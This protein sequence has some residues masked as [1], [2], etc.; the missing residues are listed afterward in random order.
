MSPLKSC[1]SVKNT[2]CAFTMAA[3]VLIMELITLFRSEL[4]HN[5]DDGTNSLL[6]GSG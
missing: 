1:K 2:E 6:T 4:R 3:K 5:S